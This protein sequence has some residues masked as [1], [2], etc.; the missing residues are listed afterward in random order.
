MRKK[1]NVNLGGMVGKGGKARNGT[2][3]HPLYNGTG[4]GVWDR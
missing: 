3:W 4:L 1:F 2:E